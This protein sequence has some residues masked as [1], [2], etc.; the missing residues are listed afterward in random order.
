MELFAPAKELF[1]Y[2]WDFVLK[3]LTAVVIFVIGW[4]VAR[5]IK[6]IVVKVLKAL[7]I[8]SIAD[9]TKIT[10][11]LSK[12]GVKYTLTELI[13]VIV[14][15]VLL[16]GV[17]VSSLNILALTG[18]TSLLDKILTYLPSVIGALMILIL[19]I[20]ISVFVASI[21]RT[22]LANVGLAQANALSKF[23]QVTIIVFA[24]IISLDQ[25]RIAAVLISAMNIVLA[26]IGLA[27]ALAFGLGCKDVANKFV[28]ELIDKLKSKK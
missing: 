17:L 20:F 16:L 10:D 12:G 14:Y 8:D 19:G 24:I 25:L 26:S 3:F 6:T 1:V 5:V 7:S 15:W 4:I 2:V 28:N 27:L 23:S 18:V 11:F 9:Q 21:I 22:A 13:G